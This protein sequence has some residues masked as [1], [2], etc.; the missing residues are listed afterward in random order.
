MRQLRAE[1]GRLGITAD[2]HHGYGM[3]LLSVWVDLVVWSDGLRFLW[4]GGQFSQATGRRT[5]IVH[6]T[7]NPAAT[8]RRIAQRYA[9]LRRTHSMSR[10]IEELHS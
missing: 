4:W 8:A 10:L 5:Y 1:L 7:G 9:D 6:S 3:A 2:L